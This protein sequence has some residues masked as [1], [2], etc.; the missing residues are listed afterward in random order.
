MQLKILNSKEKKAIRQTIDSQ[1]GCKFESDLVFLRSTKEKIC[2]MTRDFDSLD[3]SGIKI[4]SMGCYFASEKG[5]EL[6]LSIEGSEL[7]G[8]IA[9]KNVLSLN[10]ADTRLWLKGKDVPS[11]IEPVT[12]FI[13]LKNKEDYLGTAK[14]KDGMLLNFTPKNR[15]ILADD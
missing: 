3:L 8:P 14:L 5:A 9:T 11:D 12:G 15:R 2:L 13:I 4:D 6:R 1:W 7:V 10:D